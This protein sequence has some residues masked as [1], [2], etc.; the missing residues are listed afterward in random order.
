MARAPQ[1][2]D[3]APL[4]TLE[5]AGFSNVRAHWSECPSEALALENMRMFYDE[6]RDR[7]VARFAEVFSFEITKTS[8]RQLAETLRAAPATAAV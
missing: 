7:L 3:L 4:A 2:D 5:A 6:V 1:P 8:S